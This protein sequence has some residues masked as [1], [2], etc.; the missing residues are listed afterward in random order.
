[1]IFELTKE[2]CAIFGPSGREDDV[3][4]YIKNK[5]VDFVDEVT[6]DNLGNVI[7]H[8]K[9][10]GPRV[11]ISSHMDSIGLA[12]TYIEKEGFLR[13]GKIGGVPLETLIGLAVEF[14]NGVRGVVSFARNKKLS[15]LDVT[16][17]FIDIGAKNKEEAEKMISIGD[18]AVYSSPITKQGDIM[19]G[20]YMDDRIACIAQIIA[21]MNP[22]ESDKD[23]YYVFS[24]QEELGLRGATV[25]SY[26]VDPDFGIA[27]DVIATGDTPNKKDKCIVKLGNGPT[28]KIMDKAAITST[29]VRQ[30]MKEA[31]KILDIEVQD[32]IVR[33]GGTDTGAMQRARG[34]SLAGAISI[35]TRYV[36][37][38]QE[39]VNINDVEQAAKLLAMTIKML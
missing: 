31:A 5:I 9:G 17:Y 36:H 16:D 34:G 6:I 27:L 20:P 28:V 2:I 10:T 14:K 37:T 4:N 25:A 26:T 24:T 33:F 35:P 13:F 8:K 3:A 21:L 23:I 18:F 19:F 15:D 32:E 1:M 22:E 29:K 7:A 38:P 11:M 30:S 39:M 12:V